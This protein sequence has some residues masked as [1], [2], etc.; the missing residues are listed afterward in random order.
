MAIKNDWEPHLTDK[1]RDRIARFAKHRDRLKEQVSGYQKS[2][3]SLRR[4]AVQ[5]ARAANKR[6]ERA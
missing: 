2:I 4:R 6:E 5:R 3:D 1:E